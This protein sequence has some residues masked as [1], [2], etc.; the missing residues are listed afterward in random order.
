[1]YA[2]FGSKVTILQH[3]SL[4]LKH[5]DRDIADEIKPIFENKGIDIIVDAEI[6]SIDND[7]EN[8]EAIINYNIKDDEKNIS[9]DAILVATGRK[10]NTEG[11]NLEVGVETTSRGGAKTDEFLQTTVS[12]IWAMGDV[13][14]FTIYLY[15]FDDF[16]I[17]KSQLDGNKGYSL[18]KNKNVI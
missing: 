5:D 6:K 15:F 2:N 7:E 1:M 3:G 13:V 17:V 12:N 9:A 10:A 8:N 18:L 14:G 16:R 4:F 11:L